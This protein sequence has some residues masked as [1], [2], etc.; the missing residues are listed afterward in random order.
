MTT[1]HGISLSPSSLAVRQRRRHDRSLHASE[2]PPTV[3]VATPRPAKATIT[4]RASLA[5][6]A[7]SPA[8]AAGLPATDFPSSSAPLTVARDSSSHR[9]SHSAAGALGWTGL[10]GSSSASPRGRL[11]PGRARG[12]HLCFRKAELGCWGRLA[13]GGRTTAGYSLPGKLGTIGPI[14][15]LSG[16]ERTGEIALNAR[17]GRR[18]S[19][20]GVRLP[21]RC[22]FR[23][24]RRQP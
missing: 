22:G 7:F 14:Y 1:V 20:R 3:A 19:A 8:A 16:P 12:S 10:G 9:R 2:G 17:H 21:Q 13:V 11:L 23:A 15:L 4:A 5:V 18:Q 24:S 6:R